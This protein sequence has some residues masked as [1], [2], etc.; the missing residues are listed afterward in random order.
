M[1]GWDPSSANATLQPYSR[2]GLVFGRM[3]VAVAWVPA[4]L[5]AAGAGT[6]W[7]WNIQGEW[8]TW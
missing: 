3:S 2:R 1:R 8:C 5:G 6:S 7:Q 4:V